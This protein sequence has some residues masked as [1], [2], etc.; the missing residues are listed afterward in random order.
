MGVGI[1]HAEVDFGKS[2]RE[3][4]IA[5]VSK[6]R[7]TCGP[8]IKSYCSTVT[9][10]E[11]RLVLCM[12]AHDDKLTPQCLLELHEAATIFHAAVELVKDVTLACSGD[13]RTV[14][15]GI[16]PGHGRVAQC[17]ASKVDNL[18]KPCADAIE[19]LRAAAEH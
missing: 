7:T 11:G 16:Q 19:K 4:A 15:A 10:D 5:A 12:E 14:C 2:V 9:P 18:S 17:L 6:I 8:D 3:K 13:I 1:G